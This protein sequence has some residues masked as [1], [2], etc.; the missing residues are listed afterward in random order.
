[1][2]DISL[3]H[4]RLQILAAKWIKECASRGI[5]VG[6]SE[7]LRTMEEQEAL[8]AQGRTKPGPIVTNAR[9]DSYRSQHQWGIAFD[10]YL[11]MDIDGDGRVA[12]D[13]Y[14]DSTGI[15]RR[16][17]V[18]AK[19]LGLAWGGDWSS[20]V[21]KPH[22]YLPDWGSTPSKLIQI[23]GTPEAF[24]RTWKQEEGW[25]RDGIG[26]WY[27]NADGSYPANCWR[28]IHHH[29]YLFNRDGYMMTGWHRWNGSTCDPDDGAGD[30]Y[31]LDN[32]EGGTLEG[33]CWHTRD[34][35]AQEIWF[36][37]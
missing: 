15:F 5:I 2:R 1:M 19:E 31:F 12:D 33:A 10:F 7:T 3:C 36:V 22:I 27:R 13:S 4:P 26:Y 16:A 25:V 14:N 23:Y 34:S 11:L 6:I 17:A 30:W 32:T 21:D 37:D 24:I 28:V 18:V 20:I 35:G 29:W 8:Y 9:G